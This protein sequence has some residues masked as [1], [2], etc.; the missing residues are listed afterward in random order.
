MPFDPTVITSTVAVRDGVDLYLSWTSSAPSGTWYQVYLAGN[1][2]AKTKALS[3]TSPYPSDLGPNVRI[4]VGAVAQG[5]QFTDFSIQGGG[6]GRGGYGVGGYGNCSCLAPVP[7]GRV[8]LEWLGGSY[9]S[10]AIA[11]FYVYG[12]PAPG[13]PV[14]Y[15]TPLAT[16][17]AYAPGKSNDGYGLGGYGQG[18]YGRAASSYSWTSSSLSAG[19]WQF[20]VVS[21]DTAGNVDPNPPVRSYT[22]TVAPRPPAANTQGQRL[23]YSFSRGPGTGYGASGYGKGGYGAGGGP[24]G[25][26][27]YGAGRYGAGGYGAGGGYGQGG[28]GRDGYGVGAVPAGSYVT[29]N[30]LPS[31]G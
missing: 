13:Q 14:S 20:A 23:T 27:G 16:I 19:V 6:Y 28:Y 29:L 31:P 7:Y 3:A 4:A 30:W 26:G 11:G 10:A 18:G 25:T 9:L 12:S 22:I 8:K 24:A 2:A 1:L 15:A 17:S 5:E 21:F